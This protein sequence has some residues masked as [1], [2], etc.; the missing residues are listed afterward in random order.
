MVDQEEQVFIFFSHRAEAEAL[1]LATA[2]CHFPKLFMRI[3]HFLSLHQLLF[4]GLFYKLHSHMES[5]GIL[6]ILNWPSSC[7][8]QNK[9][10]GFFLQ[11][12]VLWHGPGFAEKEMAYFEDPCYLGED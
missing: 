3:F 11:M 1:H 8:L 6:Q 7:P 10:T 2:G 9:Q 12:F 5:F 4:F